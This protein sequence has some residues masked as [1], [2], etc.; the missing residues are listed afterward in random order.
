MY[1]FFLDRFYICSVW[2]PI[3]WET[4]AEVRLLFE[5]QNIFS[6]TVEYQ[7]NDFATILLQHVYEDDFDDRAIRV[8]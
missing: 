6:G 8:F 4:T 1:I 2:C 5:K 3:A 7:Y